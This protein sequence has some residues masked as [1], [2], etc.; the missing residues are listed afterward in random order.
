MTGKLSFRMPHEVCTSA[1]RAEFG[2]TVRLA[3]IDRS[4]LDSTP[5]ASTILA[6]KWTQAAALSKQCEG[7]Q[8]PWE[9]NRVKK[10]GVM[11]NSTPLGVERA[12]GVA[13]IVSSSE[14]P[15]CLS[16]VTLSLIVTS[17]SR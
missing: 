7:H 16:F 2:C 6:R 1:E 4:N 15:F 17:M 11:T 14:R 13:A 12:V 10:A 8:T 3:A 9:T 5:R